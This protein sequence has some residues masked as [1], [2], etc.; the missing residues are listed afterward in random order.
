MRNTVLGIG[1]GA[2]LATAGGAAFAQSQQPNV[3]QAWPAHCTTWRCVNN[4]LN[5]LR[6][7]QKAHG[8]QILALRARNARLR[9][10]LSEM[11]TSRYSGGDTYYFGTDTNNDGN[12]DQNNYNFTPYSWFDQTHQGDHV[13]H[14][15]LQDNCTPASFGR[16][17]AP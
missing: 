3:A 6:A 9:T 17:P 8:Q 1:L 15:M 12:F 7:H 14:W 2:V 11:P 4:H 13:D 10:C 5:L 16:P